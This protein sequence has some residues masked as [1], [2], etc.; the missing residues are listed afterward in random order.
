MSDFLN[1]E[2][3]EQMAREYNKKYGSISVLKTNVFKKEDLE[4]IFGEIYL[5]IYMLKISFQKNIKFKN[6]FESAEKLI[7]EMSETEI[8]LQISRRKDYR[9]EKIVVNHKKVACLML[10]ILRKFNDINYFYNEKL[11]KIQSMFLS[12]MCEF[13]DNI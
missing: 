2:D 4:S 13:Y 1:G 6:I 3:F 10:G 9:N 11:M 7:V 12:I 8:N 5:L